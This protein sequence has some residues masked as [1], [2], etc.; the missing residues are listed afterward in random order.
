[1][2][3][4]HPDKEAVA[5]FVNQLVFCFFANSVGLLPEGM[6]KKLLHT[7][8]RRPERA[9]HWLDQLFADGGE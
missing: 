1:L 9:K 3:H 2:Q 8:E 7:A 6:W 5:H 4:R